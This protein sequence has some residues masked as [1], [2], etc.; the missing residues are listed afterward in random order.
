MIS[1]NTDLDSRIAVGGSR[2]R[3]Q[4]KI[5]GWESRWRHCVHVPRCSTFLCFVRVDG[6]WSTWSSWSTCSPDCKHHRRRLCENPAPANGGRY[7]EGNDLNTANCNGGMCTVLGMDGQRSKFIVG[8]EHAPA[9]LMAPPVNITSPNSEVLRCVRI[10]RSDPDVPVTI[11][12]R[13]PTSPPLF[14]LSP[15]PGGPLGATPR[16]VI[17]AV[18]PVQQHTGSSTVCNW[19][20]GADPATG[21]PALAGSMP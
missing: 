12:I 8:S 1:D 11:P 18:F 19:M 2:N 17:A 20:S 3:K 21:E 10:R 5:D 16:D 13:L 4:K 9:R 7:C 15:F 14:P 6:F